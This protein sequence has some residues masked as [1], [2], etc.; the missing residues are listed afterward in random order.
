MNSVNVPLYFDSTSLDRFAAELSH[1]KNYSMPAD[2][3]KQLLL[4]ID[5]YKLQEK[6]LSRVL[7][8]R[9]KEVEKLESRLLKL[10]KESPDINRMIKNKQRDSPFGEKN[11]RRWSF[12]ESPNHGNFRETAFCFD[13][14]FLEKEISELR[15]SLEK[16][17]HKEGIKAYAKD[18]CEEHER[19]QNKRIEG[20]EREKSTLV[21]SLITMQSEKNEM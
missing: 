16:L 9:V 14:K 11:H 6:E 4:F 21:A 13:F 15:L 3:K 2:L 20:L 10:S 8:F 19:I 18:L 1:E 12:Q 7:D 17:Q 5:T